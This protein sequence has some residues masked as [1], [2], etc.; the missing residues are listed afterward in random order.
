MNTQI[1][2][3]AQ[4]KPYLKLPAK[5]DHKYSRGVVAFLT[6]SKKFPGAA[7]LSTEAALSTGVG[8]V[9]Y[10]G[11]KSVAKLVL[12]NTPE[13]VISSGRTDVYVI[14]SGIPETITWWTRRKLEK[15]LSL[16]MPT[17]LDA[18]ALNLTPKAHPMT[19]ITPHYGELAKL[20]SAGQI[21][22]DVSEIAANPSY[23]AIFTAKKFN[24][25]VLLKGNTSFIANPERVL[26]LPSSP[27]QLATAGTGDV[28]AGILGGLLA[29]NHETLNTKN[30]IEVAATACL[31]HSKAA[32]TSLE[33]S[34][35]SIL[36]VEELLTQIPHLIQNLIDFRF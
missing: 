12:L 23:W 27:P 6:G 4:A 5:S 21:K 15:I 26:Q 13:V 1:W 28:L 33:A 7:L 36:R 16:N 34:G 17:V 18:G 19:V 20:L 10:L 2:T 32:S 30:L 8:M 29:I 31:I 22:V 35:T 14:G 3:E 9:R 24:L 11:A 25:T